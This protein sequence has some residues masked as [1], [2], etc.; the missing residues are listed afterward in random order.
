MSY[1]F[2]SE[3]HDKAMVQN[4]QGFHRVSRRR[5]ILE[6]IQH[7]RLPALQITNVLHQEHS[8]PPRESPEKKKCDVTLIW[9][10][11][12]VFF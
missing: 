2:C 1:T 8:G 5:G 3:W 7:G 11:V 9:N 10:V 12:V 4:S 6:R